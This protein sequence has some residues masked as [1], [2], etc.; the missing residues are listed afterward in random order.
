MQDAGPL[1]AV[2]GGAGTWPWLTLCVF[3]CRGVAALGA[4]TWVKAHSPRGLSCH[5]R[6][7]GPF[8]GVRPPVPR[9]DEPSELAVEAEEQ[10]PTRGLRSFEQNWRGKALWAF[11]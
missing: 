11:L 8:P 9:A 6:A 2:G 3:S 1:R 10:S 5:C 4:G 7:E